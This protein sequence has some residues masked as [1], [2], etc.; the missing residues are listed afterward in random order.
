MVYKYRTSDQALAEIAELD[1]RIARYEIAQR[2]AGP[3]DFYLDKIDELK[4]ER[5]NI[6]NDFNMECKEV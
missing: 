6:I 4:R 3:D 5:R 2:I 1:N